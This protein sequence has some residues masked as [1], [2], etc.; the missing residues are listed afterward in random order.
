V[1]RDNHARHGGVEVARV[2]SGPAAALVTAAAVAK[3]LET[4]I[5]GGPFRVQRV[6]A[7]RMLDELRAIGEWRRQGTE[8][9]SR[10][11]R[12]LFRGPCPWPL[13]ELVTEPHRVAYG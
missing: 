8:R 3:D 1:G 9:C 6:G 7:L 4:V 11:E 10:L 5:E 12:Q 13:Q 2:R